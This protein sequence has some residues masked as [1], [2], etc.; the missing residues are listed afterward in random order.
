MRRIQLLSAPMFLSLAASLAACQMDSGEFQEGDLGSAEQEA[1]GG[2]PAQGKD[3]YGAVAAITIL[4]PSGDA[5]SS[6]TEFRY[7]SG[8]LIEERTVMT[9]AECLYDNLEAELDAELPEPH[10]DAA[11]VVVQFGSSI[12]GTTEYQLDASFDQPGIITK[13]LML[14]RYYDPDLRGSN[15]IALLYLS[16]APV[17]VDPVALHTAAV[18]EADVGTLVELVG[19]GKN[20]EGPGTVEEFTARNVVATA[21]TSV[22]SKRIQA[23]T[24]EATTCYADSGGPGFINFDEDPEVVSV[25]VIQTE[26]SV[27][28]NRQRVDVH[29][30]QFL[31]PYIKRVSGGCD[32]A[33]DCDVCEFDGVCE[34]DCPSRDWDCEI[35]SRAGEGCAADGDCEELGAC[36]AATDDTDFLYCDK[37]CDVND[38][39][40][41]P[42]GMSCDSDSRC[43]YEGISPGSQGATCTSPGECRSGYCENNF[44]AFECDP[45][46]DTCDTEAGFTCLPSIDNS[47]V[48]VCRTELRTGGGGFCH[49]AAGP[50]LHEG[51]RN[52]LLA[53]LGLLMVIGF[54]RRRRTLSPRLDS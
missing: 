46:A 22:S 49:A 33:G 43:V 29:V 18:T 41:C 28:V 1:I 45:A 31:A 40:S 53:G 42:A 10:L 2:A 34:E 37:P 17:G 51:A 16:E 3:H 15:D 27:S 38:A 54:F 23:G 13:G 7:C 26:C 8:V 36:I 19:Y 48:D 32:Q 25:S 5:T 11:S 35:G 14:H 39:A 12:G 24:D 52:S 9:A 30:E 6:R 44:C 21:I 20:D 4:R 47:D 50:H